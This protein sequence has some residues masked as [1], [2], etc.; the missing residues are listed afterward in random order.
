M[1]NRIKKYFCGITFILIL[2]IVSGCSSS[3][4]VY[5][6]QAKYRPSFTSEEYKHYAGKKIYLSSFYNKAYNTT[7]FYYYSPD[8]KTTYEAAPSIQSYFWYCF[9]TAFQHINVMVMEPEREGPFGMYSKQVP[10][11]M[12]EFR[13]EFSSLSDSEFIFLVSLLKDGIITYQKRFTVS[14]PQSKKIDESE[15]LEKRAYQMVDD[16]FTAIIKD[17]K[18]RK[19]FLVEKTL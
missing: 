5:V 1:K 2:L 10:H 12:R 19:A 14:M 6:Q 7:T 18:F 3:R 4:Y 11:G 9:Q 13:M 16:A 15:K 8:K 17:N